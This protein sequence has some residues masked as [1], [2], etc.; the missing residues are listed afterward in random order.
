MMQPDRNCLATCSKLHKIYDYMM[1]PGKK[2]FLAIRVDPSLR[3]TSHIKVLFR[4]QVSSYIEKTGYM[5]QRD[6]SRLAT[7]TRLRKIYDYMKTPG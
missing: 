1:T 2:S 3:V 4:L 5:M 6:R 7:C